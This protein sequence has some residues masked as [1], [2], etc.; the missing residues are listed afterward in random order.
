M[1]DYLD[2]LETVKYMS[3]NYLMDLWIPT[4][5]NDEDRVKYIDFMIERL[6]ELRERYAEE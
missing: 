5:E 4:L 6:M 2:T 3:D 1:S